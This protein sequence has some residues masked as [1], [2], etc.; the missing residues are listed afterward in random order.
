MNCAICGR[1][2]LKPALSIGR[3]NVGPVCARKANL[4]QPKERQPH[5]DVVRDTRT[6]D[7]FSEAS[8]A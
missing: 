1:R 5:T 4:L 8:H 3:M 6:R 2:L 7:L